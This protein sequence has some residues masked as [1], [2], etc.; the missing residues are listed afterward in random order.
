MLF[1]ITLSFAASSPSSYYQQYQMLPDVGE[2]NM[3]QNLP[4]DLPGQQPGF[5]YT[6]VPSRIDDDFRGAAPGRLQDTSWSSWTNCTKGISGWFQTRMRKRKCPNI[7]M[8]CK[9]ELQQR[10]CKGKQCLKI[11]NII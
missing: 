1:L 9:P 8:V 7:Q 3:Q 10:M 4:G 6:T 5:E 11:L 2:Y